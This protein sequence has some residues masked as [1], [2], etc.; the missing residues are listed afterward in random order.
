MVKRE[1][2]HAGSW[3]TGHGPTL[4]KQLDEWLSQVPDTIEGIG[5]IPPPGARVIIAPSVLE[6]P[7]CQGAVRTID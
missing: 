4:S 7:S 6:A 3:Y 5:S 1:A 2:S